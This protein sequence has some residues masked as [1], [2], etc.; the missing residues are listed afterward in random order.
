MKLQQ[1]FEGYG[2]DWKRTKLVRHSLTKDIVAENY[3][4]KLIEDYQSV[5]KPQTFCDCD[6]IISFL[7][8]TEGTYG[9]Y[10]GAYSVGGYVPFDRAKMPENFVADKGMDDGCVIFELKPLDYLSEFKDRLVIDWGL[11]TQSWCQRG[12]NE[13]EIL[14]IKPAVSKIDFKDYESVCLSFD[15]LSN[16]VF[17]PSSHKVWKDKL[18]AVAG[19]YLITDMHTGK[20]YVGSASGNG[21]IWE[22][23]ST[24]AHT[25]HGGNKYLKKLIDADSEYSRYFQYSILE[26]FPIK[27]DIKEI[28]DCETQYKEKLLSYEPYGMNNN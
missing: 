10:L 13:K 22:R 7:G 6:T 14:E 24:Y 4:A 1:L 21:G 17:N 2:I 5:Q 15:E 16:I 18:S 28:L 9:V 20:H 27:K 3:K 12:I 8:G 25:K 26:V 11:G 19:V 23:W